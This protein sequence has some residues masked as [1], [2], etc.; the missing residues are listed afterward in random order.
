VHI[1]GDPRDAKPRAHRVHSQPDGD[2]DGVC[3]NDMRQEAAGHARPRDKGQKH[4]ADAASAAASAGGPANREGVFGVQHGGRRGVRAGEHRGEAQAARIRRCGDDCVYVGD[5]RRAK[6]GD[7][8]AWQPGVVDCRH[9]L[10]DGE[11]GP[12]TRDVQGLQRSDSAA[13][14][15]PGA[16]GDARDGGGRVPHGVSAHAAGPHA[17]GPGGGP[18][19]RP[20][21]RAKAHQPRAGQGHGRHQ[22]Q[23]RAGRVHLPACGQGQDAQHQARAGGPLAVGP[24]DLQA[25]ERDDGRAH[26]ADHRGDIVDLAR[27]DGVPQVH[28]LMRGQRGLRNDRDVRPGKHHHAR[29]CGAGLGWHALPHEHDQAGQRQG[30]RLH[31]RRQA[32]PARRDH[33]TRRQCVP[34]VLQ[35]AG[36]DRRGSVAGRVVPDRRPGH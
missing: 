1:G 29:R 15:H 33:G 6:G 16:A 21:W 23:E 8:D 11:Q 24:R 10:C 13:V 9:Q 20:H 31:R 4:S 19:Q 27:G 18:A 25:A 34:R 14:A 12:G 17:G 36:A 3:N 35:A 5:D 2:D 26:A 30:A 7:P 32:V 22:G 28:V